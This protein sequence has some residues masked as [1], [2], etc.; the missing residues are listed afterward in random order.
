MF[1]KISLSSLNMRP[2]LHSKRLQKVCSVDL[3]VFLQALLI[4]TCAPGRIAR[5]S[6]KAGG[7]PT[8]AQTR[9]NR[10][11]A[12]KQIQ[13]K[14]R[15]ELVEATRIFNGVNGAPR[16]IAIVPLCPDVSAYEATKSMVAPLDADVTAMP[17]FGTWKIS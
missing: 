15:H 11:N 14:K 10:R 4:R 5:T 17:P 1:S 7:S 6:V 16:I 9:L 13:L 12:A 3:L 8:V 2:S